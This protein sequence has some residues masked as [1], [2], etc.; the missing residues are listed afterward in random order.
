MTFIYRCDTS[1]I[2]DGLFERN[3][4]QTFE[5]FSLW[6]ILKFILEKILTNLPKEKNQ[7]LICSP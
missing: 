3:Q 6:N 7:T 4:V 2:M 1:A 5:E